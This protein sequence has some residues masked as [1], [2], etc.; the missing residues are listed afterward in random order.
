MWGIHPTE[1][2]KRAAKRITPT[3]VGNTLTNMA[4]TCF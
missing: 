1:R 2:A 4:L 3:Y